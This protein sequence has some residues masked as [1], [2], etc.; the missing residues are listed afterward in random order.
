MFD[1]NVLTTIAKHSNAFTMFNM[2]Q[3]YPRMIGGV[4]AD[5]QVFIVDPESQDMILRY[6]KLSMIFGTSEINIVESCIKIC[7][8]IFV[9]SAAIA[10]IHWNDTTFTIK[11]IILDINKVP[12]DL[13]TFCKHRRVAKYIKKSLIETDIQMTRQ[14]KEQ[15]DASKIILIKTMDGSFPVVKGHMIFKDMKISPKVIINA[16]GTCS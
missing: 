4:V 15:L 2:M 11:L 3:A 7:R 1:L 12:K 8:K 10:K 9:S 5:K 13:E 16:M 14:V 6:A